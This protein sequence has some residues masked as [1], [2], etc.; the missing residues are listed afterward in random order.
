M[1]PKIIKSNIWT[2]LLFIYFSYI[3]VANSVWHQPESVVIQFI[4][5][6]AMKMALPIRLLVLFLVSALIVG[7]VKKL[8]S[9]VKWIGIISI[10]VF[11]LFGG[12]DAT[13]LGLFN[14]PDTSCSTHADC[15]VRA[16]STS[17]CGKYVCANE[18]W[19]RTKP[20]I[21][22]VFALDC[23]V[24][25]NICTCLQDTCTETNLT[26]FVETPESCLE[27]DVTFAEQCLAYAFGKMKDGCN[28][29]RSCIRMMKSDADDFCRQ[30]DAQNCELA[31][32]DAFGE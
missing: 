23:A 28:D 30:H 16:V 22:Q 12:F 13:V 17:G 26:D 24:P 1:M 11:L 20:L 4:V 10:I 25:E 6:T 31:A 9:I 19:E 29:D 18:G 8:L 7:I 27:L 15:A 2:I 32:D 3:L 14:R 5:E 21:N